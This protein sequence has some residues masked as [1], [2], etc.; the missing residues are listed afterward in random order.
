LEGRFFF[1]SVFGVESGLS[2]VDIGLSMQVLLGAALGGG[3]GGTRGRFIFLLANRRAQ[4]ALLLF[5]LS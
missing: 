1:S 4:G 3:G 5:F 2:R